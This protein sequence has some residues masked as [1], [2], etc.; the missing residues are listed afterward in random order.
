MPDTKKEAPKKMAAIELGEITVNAI[1]ENGAEARLADKKGHITT[2]LRNT[3]L[4]RQLEKGLTGTLIF[5]PTEPAPS[6]ATVTVEVKASEVGSIPA[7][8]KPKKEE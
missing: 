5:Q 6:E 7:F 1:N 4:N 2:V 3:T 8:A